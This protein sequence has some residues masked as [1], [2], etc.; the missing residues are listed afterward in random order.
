MTLKNILNK[1]FF[2]GRGYINSWDFVDLHS[3]VF[4]INPVKHQSIE[5]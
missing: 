1:H 3:N 2:F 5:I 4:I